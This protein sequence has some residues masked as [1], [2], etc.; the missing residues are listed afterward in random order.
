MNFITV[1]GKKVPITAARNSANTH[2]AAVK[3]KNVLQVL[4]GMS[5]GKLYQAPGRESRA[6]AAAGLVVISD[7]LGP[8]GDPT[9][10]KNMMLSTKGEK[11]SHEDVEAYL[12]A[13]EHFREAERG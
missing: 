1:N 8:R 11:T 7:E 3:G 6:L 10:L 9:G 4:M 13:Q 5:P 12:E 2:L